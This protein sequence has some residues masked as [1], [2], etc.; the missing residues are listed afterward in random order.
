M[1]CS[2]L[3][4]VSG[5]DA[6]VNRLLEL[7]SNREYPGRT[8]KEKERKEKEKKYFSRFLEEY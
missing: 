6:D 7:L 5:C 3:F 8:K 4:L 1:C 2:L